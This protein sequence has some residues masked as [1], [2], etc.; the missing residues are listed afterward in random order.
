[1]DKWALNSG[2]LIDLLDQSHR[3]IT[4]W[5]ALGSIDRNM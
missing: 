1:L 4:G 5:W 3:T 2:T